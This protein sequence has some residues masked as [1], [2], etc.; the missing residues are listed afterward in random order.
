M[1]AQQIPSV[2]YT[3]EDGIP[4]S[5]VYDIIQDEYG[6]LWFASD[7]GLSRYDG[8]SFVNFDEND[9]LVDNV[10]FDFHKR[11]NGDIWCTTYS[12]KLFVIRGRQPTFEPYEYNDTINKYC[13]NSVI[14]GVYF[15]NNGDV[16]ITFAHRY[17]FL[18]IDK[19]GEVLIK[20]YV[21]HEEEDYVI[22][23][24]HSNEP[25]FFR[26]IGD[27]YEKQ[28]KGKYTCRIEN[29]YRDGSIEALYLGE[30]NGVILA[31]DDE[32]IYRSYNNDPERHQKFDHDIIATGLVGDQY[33]IGF[34]YGGVKLYEKNGTEIRHFLNDKSVTQLYVDH[35]DGIWISTLEHG[36]FKFSN[37]DMAAV[38]RT[39]G[40]KITSLENGNK[41]NI[42]IGYD[43]GRVDVIAGGHNIKNL[44]SPKFGFSTVKMLFDRKNQNLYFSSDN[45]MCYSEVNSRISTIDSWKTRFMTIISDRFLLYGYG[46]NFRELVLSSGNKIMHP[47]G[48]MISDMISFNERVYYCNRAG[49]FRLNI[50][51]IK[52]SYPSVYNSRVNHLTTFNELLTLS[53]NGSGIVLMDKSHNTKYSITNSNGLNSNFIHKTYAENDSILWVCTNKGINRIEFDEHGNYTIKGLS[54]DDGLLSNE[55][56]DLIVSNGKIWIGTQKGLNFISQNDV[57]QEK[58]TINY[59][60]QWTGID[61]NETKVDGRNEFFHHENEFKFRYTGVSYSNMPGLK[62]RYRLEGLQGKWNFTTNRN[63]I[64]SALSP[65][66]YRLIVQVKGKNNK[67]SSNSID[68]SFEIAPPFWNTWWF[69]VSIIIAVILLIYWFFKLRILIYNKDLVREFMRYILHKIRKDKPSVLIKHKGKEIR[70]NTYDIHYIKTDRNYLEL[71]TQS[72]KYIIRASISEFLEMV[73][74]KLE[75]IQVHRSYI[76]RIEHIKQKGKKELIVLDESIPVGRKYT[77]ELDIVNL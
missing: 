15:N 7:K 67:W 75:F 28:L 26:D 37:R 46:S 14:N 8:Y 43:F 68:Y 4:S 60:L 33:W 72:E 59:Y 22:L 61:L 54:A 34:R 38:E 20:S 11:P 66:K 49:V 16:F 47:Y 39:I 55:V 21:H 23:C 77:Q 24:D 58:E 17:G 5:Q 19:N 2:S 64:F 13:C 40:S 50:S 71:F 36:V 18:Q 35:E 56:W 53:T 70:L 6:Y 42:Y 63:L 44:Y 74:D 73:P 51:D 3:T 65:G 10:I 12:S 29:Q 27:A 45:L 31:F 57:F 62:Y 32:L 76:V 9:G 1:Y 48:I 41:G 30:E 52:N 25:F 69:I